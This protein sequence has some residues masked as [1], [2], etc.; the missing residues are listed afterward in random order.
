MNSFDALHVHYFAS[1]RRTSPQ[2]KANDVAINL[3]DRP[4]G[5]NQQSR[6]AILKPYCSLG[7]GCL[8]SFLWKIGD[9]GSGWRYRFNLFRLAGKNGRVSQLFRPADL[10]HFVKLVQVMASVISDD[11]CL[12]PMDR[13]VMRRLATDLDELLTRG[14]EQANAR[15][16]SSDAEQSVSI[17]T[18]K[19]FPHGKWTYS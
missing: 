13:G 5:R 9:Q 6:T 11:G 4:A 2:R 16:A 14:T 7:A 8:S 19:E 15:G 1:A 12:S 17:S 18:T 3:N 10:M